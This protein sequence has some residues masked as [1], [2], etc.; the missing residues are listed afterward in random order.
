MTVELG[1]DQRVAARG[2]ASRRPG[3]CR[4]PGQPVVDTDTVARRT[5]RGQAVALGCQILLIG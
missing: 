3:R 5:Q 2:K 1:S 4:L